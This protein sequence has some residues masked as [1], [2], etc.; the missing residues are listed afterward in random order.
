MIQRN[1]GSQTLLESQPD[2]ST[3]QA[4]AI[5][6]IQPQTLRKSFS[7][8]GEYFGVRPRKAANR[9]LFWD[10]AAIRALKGEVA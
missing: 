5:L 10:A 9:R 8:R 4:A 3:G 6:H 1:F 7:Q 2:L